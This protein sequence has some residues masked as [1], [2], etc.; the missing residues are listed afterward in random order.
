[1]AQDRVEV[2]R[3]VWEEWARGDMKAAVDLF[4]PDVRF[5]SFMP[6]ASEQVIAR[7]PAEIERFMRE[8]LR[9]WRDYR[10][11]ADEISELGDDGVLVAG[12]QEAAGRHSGATVADTLFSA[13]VFEGDRVVRLS[14]DRDREAALAAVGR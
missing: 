8:F 3:G 5:V 2:V 12:R 4:D 10:L 9:H 14:F 13:W 6:D 11:I 1:M 7:G